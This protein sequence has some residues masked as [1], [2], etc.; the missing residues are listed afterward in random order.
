MKN[1]HLVSSIFLAKCQEVFCMFF[2]KMILPPHR[3][4]N[5][6]ESQFPLNSL[7]NKATEIKAVHC[8]EQPSR[9][10]NL[11]LPFTFVVIDGHAPVVIQCQTSDSCFI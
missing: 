1:D 5:A 6:S 10:L 8:R 2:T 11:R 9:Q 4:Q 7:T 3:C